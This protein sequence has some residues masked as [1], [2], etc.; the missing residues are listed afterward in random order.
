MRIGDLIRYK[1]NFQPEPYA[2]W[3]GPCLVTYQ[4]PP[5]DDGLWNILIPARFFSTGGGEGVIDEKNYDIEVISGA[6]AK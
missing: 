4:Y 5:P 3:V 6:V 1:A 2:L